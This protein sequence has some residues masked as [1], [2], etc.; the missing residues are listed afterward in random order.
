MIECFV[1]LIPFLIQKW[2]LL[3]DLEPLIS[4]CLRITIISMH[5]LDEFRTYIMNL[6]L[7]DNLFKLTFLFPLII[8]PC[9]ASFQLTSK[10]L[11]YMR[12]AIVLI[13]I[14]VF[15]VT[16]LFQL[17]LR[18]FWVFIEGQNINT[19]LIAVYLLHFLAW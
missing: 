16:V 10:I 9:L 15:I 2:L 5:F 7:F 14:H 13:F 12:N 1:D 17:L 4:D 18:W 6:L 8:G 11:C 19:C 3:W